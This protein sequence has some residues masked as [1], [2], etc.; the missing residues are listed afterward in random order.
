MLILPITL[1]FVPL[2]IQKICKKLTEEQVTTVKSLPF[3]CICKNP[4]T[5]APLSVT[6][7]PLR[8]ARQPRSFLGVLWQPPP[9]RAQVTILMSRDHGGPALFLTP[10]VSPSCSVLN[11]HRFKSIPK[12]L[13][14]LPACLPGGSAPPQ[15]TA[16][17]L[18][19]GFQEGHDHFTAHAKVA[20]PCSSELETRQICHPPK[21]EI[22]T[23]MVAL[24]SSNT[25][26]HRQSQNIV[27]TKTA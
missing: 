13:P 10:Y 26:R 25:Y 7:Q 8:A 12:A 9:S 1:L 6:R 3:L 5:R 14:L 20:C 21:T 2:L 11:I 19:W 27:E 4:P 15:G 18:A 24:R 17:S 22:F 23:P 16:A